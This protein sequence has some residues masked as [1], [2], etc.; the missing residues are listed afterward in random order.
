[1]ADAP[2]RPWIPVGHPDYHWTPHGDCQSLWRKYGWT[3]PSEKRTEF[4]DE[5]PARKP[6]RRQGRG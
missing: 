2:P 4:F 6:A 1:M 3:P 5:P